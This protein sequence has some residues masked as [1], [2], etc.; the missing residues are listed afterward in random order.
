MFTKQQ[1]EEIALKLKS[2]SKK[3]SDFEKTSQ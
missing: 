3:D 1:I 2:V